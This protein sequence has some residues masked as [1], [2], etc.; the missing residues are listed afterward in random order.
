[1][2]KPPI[3]NFVAAYPAPT[4]TNYTTVLYVVVLI[5]VVATALYILNEKSYDE[6][7]RF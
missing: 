5:V 7:K 2:K 6:Q 4:K 3:P 1:M